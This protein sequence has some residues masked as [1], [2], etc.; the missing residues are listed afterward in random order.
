MNEILAQSVQTESIETLLD[1]K[2][3]SDLNKLLRI[4]DYV[5]KFINSTADKSDF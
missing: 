2:M 4:T 3:F 1:I 5:L